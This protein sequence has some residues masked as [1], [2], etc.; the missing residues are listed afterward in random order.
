MG[1]N[2]NLVSRKAWALMP[3]REDVLEKRRPLSFLKKVTRIQY[4]AS[5]LIAKV[6]CT[7]A[8]TTNLLF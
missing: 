6:L 1:P 4:V 7:I 8:T 3:R 2:N 5:L